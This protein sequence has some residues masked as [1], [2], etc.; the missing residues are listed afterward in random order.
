MSSSLSNGTG[1]KSRKMEKQDF[2]SQMTNHSMRW[3][4]NEGR[5]PGTNPSVCKIDL[6]HSWIDSID[7][8]N[9][10]TKDKLKYSFEL[11]VNALV[12]KFNNTLNS[13]SD[14]RKFYKQCL[15]N[16]GVTLK[17]GS[18]QIRVIPG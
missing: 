4:G 8:P 18:I 12:D 2:E 14:D 5:K 9:D 7:N 6:I 13:E 16:L 15:K 11:T 1:W 10:V 17:K 3:Q